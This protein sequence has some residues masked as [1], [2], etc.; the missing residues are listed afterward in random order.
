MSVVS[1]QSLDSVHNEGGD[2]ALSSA[3]NNPPAIEGTNVNNEA[4]TFRPG[5][6]FWA[7]IF[8]LCVSAV[9]SSLEGTIVS[10][11][12]PSIVRDLG[13]GDK[14]LWAANAYFLTR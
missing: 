13:G 6:R 2:G 9:C 11:A 14:F 12:L 1:L 7:I 8:A 5:A 3:P 10:T 4:G